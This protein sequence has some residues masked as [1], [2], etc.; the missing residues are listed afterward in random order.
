MKEEYPD[1]SK[2]I[3]PK[4]AEPKGKEILTTGFF[5]VG[6]GTPETKGRG[7]VGIILFVGRSP[8]SPRD[9]GQ[10]RGIHWV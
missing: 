10:Q 1:V 4:E 7:H 9:R 5:G 3:D 2:D 6:L 8:T